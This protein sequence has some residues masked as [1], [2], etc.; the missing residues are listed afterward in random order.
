MQAYGI[1]DSHASVV[2]EKPIPQAQLDYM[3]VSATGEEC[4]EQQAKA[5]CITIVDKDQ[6]MVGCVQ[7]DRK[8]DDAF[9]VR[10]VASFMDGMR[11]E[12]VRARYDN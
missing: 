1:S 11:A 8:G 7:V 12:D 4:S 6:G 2:T 3:Y 9:A 5:T 10:F